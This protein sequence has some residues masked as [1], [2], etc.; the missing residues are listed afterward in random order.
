MISAAERARQAQAVAEILDFVREHGLVL[1][2]LI[3]IG[4]EDHRSANPTQ[5][6]KARAVSRCW[7]LIARLGMKYAALDPA[8]S[9]ARPIILAIPECQ[10]E[11]QRA[12]AQW[13]AKA[14]EAYETELK[15]R[16][17][18]NPEVELLPLIEGRVEDFLPSSDAPSREFQFAALP[19][20]G[21]RSRAQRGGGHPPESPL[22]STTYEKGA[23]KVKSLKNNKKTDDHSVG[24]P[25]TSPKG[26]WKH[27]RRLAPVG[28]P[29][30]NPELPL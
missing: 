7:E 30:R 9:P 23:S 28:D 15:K 25:G 29:D 26:R 27:K 10:V 6:G 11:R 2:D 8:T 22:F 17:L 16:Q 4:G 24:S 18:K 14:R 1:D 20:P 12:W 19:E 13:Y 3:E 5:A 21:F